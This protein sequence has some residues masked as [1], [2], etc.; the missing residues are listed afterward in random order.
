MVNFNLSSNAAKRI[1]E[2]SKLENKPPILRLSVEGGGCS[3]FQYKY[4]LENDFDESVDIK[5]FNNDVL[6]LIDETSLSLIS[7]GELDYIE[8]LEG[9]YFEITNPNAKSGCGCGNSFSI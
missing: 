2:L 7:G 9:S 6:L 4:S 5:I 8:N 1:L 3:G